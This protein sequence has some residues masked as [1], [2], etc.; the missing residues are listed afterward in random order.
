MSFDLHHAHLFASDI[1]ATIDW[2]CRHL[3][4]KVLLDE[5][6]AGARNVLLAIGV[7]RLN[8]YDQPPRDQGRGAVHHLG[9]KVANLRE[10]WRRLQAEGV[11]S[12]S[13]LREHAHWRYVMVSAPDGV[14]VEL[15]EFDDPLAPA[16]IV[17]RV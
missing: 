17:G 12:K 4:A 15:F 13:G 10:V 6:L 7:G 5:D 14:L 11:M 8:I 9:V 1:N 3:Q 16:N 2:W